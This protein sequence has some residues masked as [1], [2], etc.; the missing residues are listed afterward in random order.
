MG[1]D[2]FN[3]THRAIIRR[4][5]PVSLF[6]D[7]KTGKP[8]SPVIL[9]SFLLACAYFLVFFLC[10]HF[11]TDPLFRFVKP[12]PEPVNTVVHAFL[13]SILGTAVCCLTFFLKDKRLTPYAFA[14]LGILFL[15]TLAASVSLKPEARSIMQMVIVMY[16]LS[17]VL[18]GNLV[19]WSLYLGILKKKNAPS[20]EEGSDRDDAMKL[21]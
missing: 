19:S 17:P 18:I 12:G 13:I 4:E 14:I 7:K 5:I 1:S 15:M 2:A 8:K 3:G 9:Y 10:F 11:L 6:V 16:G 20:P 21:Y